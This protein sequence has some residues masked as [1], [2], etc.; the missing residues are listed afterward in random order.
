MTDL[1]TAY[2]SPGAT[3]SARS[4]LPQLRKFVPSFGIVP[5]VTLIGILTVFAAVA[6]SIWTSVKITEG[7]MYRRA[8]SELTINIKLLD[9]ILAA[10]GRPSRQGEKLYFGTT[11]ING[12]FEP[13]DRVKT[14]AGGTATVFLGDLR[15][16]TNVQK[17][18]GARAIGTK[19]APG[20][21]Y[22]AVFGQRQTYRGEANILGEPY[23]T[24]YEPISSGGSVI[25]IAY[26]GVKKAQFF[27]VLRSLVT[28][29][30]AAG[31]GVIL[32][33]GLIM[34]F[35]VR[36]I[37][38]PIGMIRRE[39]VGMA[40]ATMQQELDA[41]TLA[42]LDVRLDAL[43]QTLYA[44]GEPRREGDTLLF[45][46]KPVNDD[47]ALVDGIGNT[48]GTLVTVFAGDRRV[49]TNVRKA[50]GS[51]GVGTRLA[52]GPVYDRV[53]KQAKTYRGSASI[54]DTPHF[55][56]YEP[57]LADGDVVG[58]LF[59][60]KPRIAAAGEQATHA[61]AMRSSD[62]IGKMRDAVR[63]LGQ[64]AKAREIAEQEA[65]EQR[66]E[67]R[68]AQ[69]RFRA[70]QHDVQR[71]M[72]D[73]R[74]RNAQQQTAVVTALAGGLA[75]L[76]EGDL[77]A[78]LNDG[79]TE[80]S[81]QIRDDF[82]AAVARLRDTIGAIVAAT[83]EVASAAGEISGSTTDLAQRTEEQAAS[84]EQTSA[85]MEQISATAKKNAENAQHANRSAR[86]VCEVAERSGQVVGRA[87]TAMAKIETSSGKIADIIS[88]ID[89][90][91]R[92]TNLLALNAAVEAARAG[93]AGRGFAVV[94]SEVRSL[95]QRSSQAAKDIK[96]LITNS[97]GEVREGVAL[98]NEAGGAL[99][100]IV[101]SIKEVAG[102][103]ADI[104]SAS[105]EQSSGIEQ[106]NRALTQMDE[107]TQQN[108]ALVEQTAAASQLLETQAAA[109]SKRAGMFQIEDS[110][111]GAMTRAAPAAVALRR[112]TGN[113]ALIK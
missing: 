98:V 105:G 84:L 101:Q 41:R 94:A 26:V 73:E 79:F 64:A 82:N 9:S 15:V 51:R 90:I 52:A 75:K 1:V 74:A 91:A 8:Q 100:G 23:L 16:S 86:G 43:R 21:A 20:P 31:A 60:G 44:S 92:Q 111:A 88:V 71:R 87:V 80:S 50:D 107:I 106:V 32:L 28:T 69:R 12:N 72:D 13:V 103:V 11:L 30:I 59:V 36:R 77:T 108:S 109:M 66:Q 34:Y 70:S 22:D 61:S 24:I 49:T 96:D 5:R 45:G 40:A 110:N 99:S 67:A 48:D 42:A 56:I 76:S 3:A 38:R 27:S 81:Q 85:A 89:E 93:E 6:V 113:L 102:V 46:N 97:S 17:P 62:E 18:D 29:N 58:I 95:A 63:E 57:I 104:A 37:L 14:V 83:R 19:L 78:R 10:Y 7:E 54:F 53:L 33:A 47:L 68:D 35:L 39:L 65:A 2:P 112:R 55:A 25:G 4:M